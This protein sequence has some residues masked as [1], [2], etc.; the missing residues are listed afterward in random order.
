MGACQRTPSEAGLPEKLTSVD[1]VRLN[2]FELQIDARIRRNEK[3]S[4]LLNII[5]L[6]REKRASIADPTAQNP[7]PSDF[8]AT[9]DVARIDAANVSSKRTLLAAWI[10]RGK[11]KIVQRRIVMH[12]TRSL[13]GQD[14]RR[15]VAPASDQLRSKRFLPLMIPALTPQE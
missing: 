11:T 3:Q 15:A 5:T 6:L 14:E 7:M 4:A 13:R 12:H 10:V 9:A 1:P 8:V 2:H